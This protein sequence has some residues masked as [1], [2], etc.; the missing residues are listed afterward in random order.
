[1]DWQIADFVSCA[2]ISLVMI[3][4]SFAIELKQTVWTGCLRHFSLAA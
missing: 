1:M 3:H 2:L 4:M